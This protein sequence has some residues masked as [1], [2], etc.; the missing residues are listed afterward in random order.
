MISSENCKYQIPPFFCTSPL[1]LIT[2]SW[3]LYFRD[4]QH[5]DEGDE[6]DDEDEDDDYGDLREDKPFEIN[7][8]PRR[9]DGGGGGF[10]SSFFG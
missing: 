6:Y 1:I 10:F 7:P 2:S 4:E 8:L 5:S 9:G 3:F